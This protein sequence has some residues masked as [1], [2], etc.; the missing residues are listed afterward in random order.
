MSGGGKAEQGFD[1]VLEGVDSIEPWCPGV[2]E[3]VVPV[4]QEFV[5]AVLGGVKRSTETVVGEVDAF[6][7]V[8]RE[9]RGDLGVYFLAG[10]RGGHWFYSD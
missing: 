6:G 3:V 4:A 5:D 8:A 10:E 1:F 7:G 9:E 2:V